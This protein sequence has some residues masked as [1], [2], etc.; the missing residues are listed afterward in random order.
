[1]WIKSIKY[2]HKLQP[3]KIHEPHREQ[4]ISGCGTLYGTTIEWGEGFEIMSRNQVILIFND[5]NRFLHILR[6]LDCW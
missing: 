6:V 1:M 4:L 3:N 2:Q 5:S